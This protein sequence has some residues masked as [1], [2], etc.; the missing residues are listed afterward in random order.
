MFSAFT[1]DKSVQLLKLIFLMTQ[2]AK[3]CLPENQLI[4]GGF[5]Y[6]T[7]EQQFQD[8]DLRQVRKEMRE[9]SPPKWGIFEK[10]GDYLFKYAIIMNSI[11]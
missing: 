10:I 7:V 4:F 1:D 2:C 9:F 3:N 11:S 6:K 5:W 8:T